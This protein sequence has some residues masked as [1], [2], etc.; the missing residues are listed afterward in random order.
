MVLLARCEGHCSHTTRSD[1]LISFSSVLKQPFKSSCSC[2]RPH[3][4][5]LK[6]IRL[7]CAGGTRITATYRY[8]L[9]CNCEECSWVV[10]PIRWYHSG[11]CGHCSSQ[12]RLKLPELFFLI[13]WNWMRKFVPELALMLH[14]DDLEPTLVQVSEPTEPQWTRSPSGSSNQRESA[15]GRTTQTDLFRATGVRVDQELQPQTDS[16]PTLLVHICI[17][18]NTDPI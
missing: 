11:D 5:K 3:T 12:V 10:L 6:A 14:G 8:I 16:A 7:R 13:I 1:P 18:T 4:S 17:I 9:A 15:E 2:C